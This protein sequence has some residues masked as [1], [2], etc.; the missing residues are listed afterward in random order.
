MN[1]ARIWQPKRFKRFIRNFPTSTGVALIETDAG[2]CYLK[3]LGNPEGPHALAAEWIG[4]Q[5]AAEFGLST[6]DIALLMLE[7]TS[8]IPLPKGGF[9]QPGP[10]FCTRQEKGFPWGGTPEELDKLDNPED[11]ARL[12]VFDTWV[13][14]TDRHFPDPHQRRPNRDN[15]FLST[16]RADQ[17]RYRLLAMDHTHCFM[18]GGELGRRLTRIERIREDRF[19][20][21]F[22]EFAAYLS[23]ESL[24]ICAQDLRR[25]TPSVVSPIVGS[26]PQEWEVD[27]VAQ[28]ALVEFLC[29]RAE[30][31]ADKISAL[32]EQN[33]DNEFKMG[34]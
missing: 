31:L 2:P 33:L 28:S 27:N 23:R 13:L 4:T 10:A 7:E 16:E 6:F 8:E 1:R 19:Y 12:V 21:L 5:L 30:F 3:A 32:W 24:M 18:H 25:F 20:G 14:N 11:I 26:V 9:A 22:P 34:S 17:G 29:R 15:V